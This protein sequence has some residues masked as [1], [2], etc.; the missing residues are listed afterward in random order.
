MTPADRPEFLRV[1]NGLAAV[2]GSQLTPEALDLWWGAFADWT[3]V[4][5]KQAAGAT[6]TRCK[7]MPRPADLFEV[8]RASV[9]TGGEAWSV[10]GKSTDARA[11]KALHIATQ[12]RY[13]G[14]IPL[15]EL[16]WVQ[17]RFLEIYEQLADV[18]EARKVAGHLVGPA[19]HQVSDSSGLRRLMDS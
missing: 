7:F 11:D 18:D 2:F 15:D 3:L 17:K 1:M 12:G 16:P 8:K 5:F 4:D 14:H 19:R 13:I 10:A 9:L 6:V